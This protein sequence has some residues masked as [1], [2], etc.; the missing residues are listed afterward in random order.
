[1]SAARD[2]LKRVALALRGEY[3][4]LLDQIAAR[5]WETVPGYQQ[6]VLEPA[7]LRARIGDSVA[8]VITCLLEG[9]EPASG[10]LS[11]AA[12]NG[13]RRALQGV[14]ATAV[15]QSY[16]TAERILGDEFQGWCTRMQV[17]P[18]SARAG[19]AALIR[20]LDLLERA[21]LDAYSEIQA[22]VEADQRLSEPTLFRRFAAGEAIDS[23][24]IE[25]LA[26]AV[27]V[28][29]PDGARFIAVAVAPRAPRDR[30]W[31]EQARHRLAAILGRASGTSV[32]SGTVE[33]P[34]GTVVLLALPSDAPLDAAAHEV[35]DALGRV[36]DGDLRACLG[37][38]ARG[39]A[40][41]GSACREALA[42]LA[43]TMPA[44]GEEAPRGVLLYIDTLLPVLLDRD[45]TLA[46]QLADHCLGPLAGHTELLVTL[47][48]HVEAHLSLSTT[49]AVLGVHKN[50]VTY[51]LSRIGDLTGLDLH[52][53]ND[54]AQ[55]VLALHA[56][57]AL[58][59][60][61]G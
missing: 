31:L 16:R 34:G 17:R 55:V 9:R 13:E 58:D 56:R 51:R 21:M 50:T 47:R 14:S 11:R 19:R 6:Y 49:A 8:N 1:V 5:V 10:E 53:P 41:L 57:R 40:M 12:R 38:V 46:R 27:G 36:G 45:P 3:D 22:Q 39:L 28:D 25:R 33:R 43:A 54:L 7:D 24:E 37:G 29:D 4:Q 15:I 32:L 20:N 60:A 26:R 59:R 52:D 42:A 48:A 2:D 30:T 23:A 35:D 61:P 18:A 44:A